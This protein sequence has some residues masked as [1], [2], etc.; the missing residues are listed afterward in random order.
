MPKT[1][2]S[3]HAQDTEISLAELRGRSARMAP[4][5]IVAPSSTSAPVPHSR[6]SGVVVSTA[7]AR[8]VSSMPAFAD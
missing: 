4:H 1:F 7:S 3:H 5:W 2:A 6:I 8:L